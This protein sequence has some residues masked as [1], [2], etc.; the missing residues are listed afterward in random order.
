MSKDNF[1]TDLHSIL[2]DKKYYIPT[3]QRNYEWETKNIEELWRDLFGE[4][5]WI[6]CDADSIEPHFMGTLVTCP[7]NRGDENTD[8]KES[9]DI[10]D[11]QQRLTTLSIFLSECYIRMSGHKKEEDEYET[12]GAIKSCLK[13][14]KRRIRD[15]RTQF[16]LNLQPSLD[17][18]IFEDLVSE[19]PERAP[20][21]L[22][23]LRNKFQRNF[24]NI[25]IGK[26][27]LLNCI[28]KTRELMEQAISDPQS[29]DLPLGE[30]LEII[31]QRLLYQTDFLLINTSST[32]S[33]YKIFESL[34]DRGVDLSQADLIKNKLCSF[35][36]DDEIEDF[37]EKWASIKEHVGAEPNGMVNYLRSYAI[38]THGSVTKRELLDKFEEE[39][40]ANTKSGYT[41]KQKRKKVHELIKDLCNHAVKYSM[42]TSPEEEAPDNCDSWSGKV[43]FLN[44]LQAKTCRHA[45]LSALMNGYKELEKLI[46]VITVVQLRN[47]IAD[48]NPNKAEQAHC[49]VAKLIGQKNGDVP[50]ETIHKIYIPLIQSNE[51][52]FDNFMQTDAVSIPVWRYILEQIHNLSPVTEMEI[53]DT[54]KVHVEHILAIKAHEDSIAESRLSGHEE[55]KRY[56]HKVGNL[57]L[58]DK[59]LNIKAQNDKFSIKNSEFYTHSRIPMNDY[60]KELSIWTKED[61]EKRT[62]K[63]CQEV[64]KIWQHPNEGS[65][66]DEQ[67]V[68]LFKAYKEKIKLDHNI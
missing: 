62:S 24:K 26:N 3:L 41:I 1:R 51:N 10:L 45:L 58:L 8:N 35:L 6:K 5:F 18:T 68:K 7:K 22:Q 42:L 34:N 60:F 29:T 43:L 61:I 64:S 25:K 40:G 49:E 13:L 28:T 55:L 46:D 23:T 30:R 12:I 14:N 27:K 38:S 44:K 33:A 2:K 37:G 19:L 67:L 11:G 52:F 66:T 65:I 17:K 57:T 9:L 53:S 63:L 36:A 48:G 47:V 39:I 15:N 4:D 59:K 31:A 16:R 50:I 20:T 21:D 56:V 54:S 32:T